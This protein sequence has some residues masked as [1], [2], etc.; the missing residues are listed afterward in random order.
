MSLIS[1]VSWSKIQGSKDD[2]WADRISHLWTV[3]LLVLFTL[4]ISSAQYVGDPIQCWCPAQFSGAQV[5][6]TKSVCWISN[7]YYFPNEDII[8]KDI[9]L[10]QEKE[11]NYYQWVP[12]IFMFQALMFKVPNLIWRL[13]NG[14]GGLNMDRLVHL[15]ES[16]Q[17]S[18]SEDRE[19]MTY[20]VA[21]YI[22]RWLKA[23]RQ[24]HY[25]LLVRLRQRFANVFCFW[26]AKR[27]G[28]F[29]TGFY[30][31]IKGMYAANVIG[32]FFILNSFMAM[33]FTVYGFEVLYKLFNEGEFNDSPRFPRVTLCD[34]ELR[35]LSNLHRYTV[36]CV[37]PIN[38]FNEKIFIFLWFW[39]FVIAVIAC[40]SYL[41]WLYYFLIGYNR[42]RFVKKYLMINDALRNEKDSK[43]ARKFADEY[44]RDDGV[45]VLRVIAKN[46][47]E[48]VLTDLI[49]ILWSLYRENPLTIKQNETRNRKMKSNGKV[50]SSTL[51]RDVDDNNSSDRFSH[52]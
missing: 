21:K 5:G 39:Y 29:L 20:Q 42:Y 47:S 1:F 8:P 22:D 18:K 40:G 41:L 11:I 7:T 14:V 43:F 9:T 25:N 27:E 34:F 10:R 4:L 37:L 38:L 13:L 51:E 49:C 28:K 31:L 36:Q 12:F 3:C 16:A 30:L 33:N 35:Q 32:Q 48:L 6:Y 23:H 45:F 19:K 52:N 2:D 24:Y 26:F 44:L 17:L 46:S 50:L 15:A